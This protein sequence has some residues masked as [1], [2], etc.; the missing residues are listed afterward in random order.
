MKKIFISFSLVLLLF[1]YSQALPKPNYEKSFHWKTNTPEK[2]GMSS[3]KLNKITKQYKKF[4][5]KS[6]SFLVVKNGY[7]I[8]EKYYDNFNKESKFNVRSVTKSVTSALFGIAKD[9]GMIKNENLK[10][11]QFFPEYKKYFKDKNKKKLTLKHLLTMTGGFNWQFDLH[12]KKGIFWKF[13]NSKKPIEFALSIPMAH[14]PGKIGQYNSS[15]THILSG[16]ITKSVKKDLLT[17]A[18][19]YL[20]K[21]L[22]FKNFQ[23][24][25]RGKYREG[26]SNLHLRP[27]D[28][29]KI[30]YL[31]SSYGKLNNKQII[32]KKWVK[33]STKTKNKIKIL[34]DFKFEYAYCWYPIKWGKTK[35]YLAAGV[36]GQYIFV[37]PKDDLVVVTT[38]TLMAFHNA[39]FY[40]RM[41]KK[42]AMAKI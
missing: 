22:S 14:E 2:L 34:G 18:K 17:F 39:V 7:L 20:F 6:S 4:A 19:K 32:S 15:L 29:A 26:A 8:Y 40:M 11:A 12:N 27:R 23:W 31:F 16:V 41:F 13:F 9:K 28:M 33:E 24:E 35:G 30:G 36:G 21:P 37:V 42:T 25:K 3:E 5:P 38:S 10:V 1:S